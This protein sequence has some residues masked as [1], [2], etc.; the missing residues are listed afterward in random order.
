ME[1]ENRNYAFSRA[2]IDELARSGL[3]HACICPG[4]RS[5]P[6]TISLAQQKAI[7]TWVHLDERS[8][9]F[10][11]LGIA[12]AL[13]EPVAVVCTSGTAAANFHPA[14]AEARYSRAPLLVITSDRPPELSEWGAAQIIDQIG[15]YGAHVKWAVNMP[16][17]EVTPDLLRYVRAVACRVYDTSR[18]TVAGPVHVNIPF[19]EPLVPVKVEQNF[20]SN[21]AAEA[22]VAWGG[23][24]NG[25]AYVKASSGVVAPGR[26]AI[27]RIAAD[28]R[29]IERGIIVC[30]PQTEAT[31]GQI[32]GMASRLG[33]PVLADP[34]SQM[35]TG[36]HDKGLVVSSYD[37][38]LK[39]PS[40]AGNFVQEAVLRF[41]DIPT[42][43]PVLQLLEKANSARQIV[44]RSGGWSDPSHMA[45]DVIHA[46]PGLVCEGLGSAFGQPRK[47]T[48]WLKEWLSLDASVK[49][50]VKKHL[51]G[52][53]EFFEGKV[54]SE[55]A[56]MLPEGGAIFA[57]NSMPV[58]D[59]DAFLPS[60]EK[61]IR[62]MSN[63]GVNGIDGVVS[64]A[65][66]A[67]AVLKERLVL[68][69]G[70]ISFYHDMNGLLAAKRYGLNATIIVVNNDGGGIFSFL[71]QANHPDVFEE[72]FGTPH[73][74]E[75][76]PA[77]ELY[78]LSYAKVKTWRDFRDCVSKSFSTPGT[79]IIE[80]PSD[81]ARNLKLHRE[82]T[83]AVVPH[84]RSK[85]A[86]NA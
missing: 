17:P 13:G 75:F 47:Q 36:K 53:E 60:T 45:S 73:G 67:S 62:C 2:F 14:V 40:I 55:L 80:A 65:L 21:I 69:I 33:Y 43:K 48:A 19:R 64:T 30:G 58:R 63:R 1:F 34:L 72:Y 74:M 42:S 27:E 6:L 59:M 71:P 84:G 10:F 18:A 38:F 50:A 39:D 37:T 68:V 23:R 16:T 5:S 57:G 11:A 32:V 77:A 7:K 85:A 4:S 28:L 31:P 44:V 22:G 12:K 52:M 25:Q 46:D 66:G 76:R 54:F 8:A 35:R 51:D 3:R 9:A 15:M 41:G 24:D 83:S 61:T 86:R 49:A 29:A 81:R 79:S 82:L 56:D 70:D 78:G 20:P 26:A